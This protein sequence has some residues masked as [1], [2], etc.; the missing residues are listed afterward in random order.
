MFDDKA[1]MSETAYFR[2]PSSVRMEVTDL[3]FGFLIFWVRVQ[4]FICAGAISIGGSPR[5]CRH[6]GLRQNAA[7]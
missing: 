7:V 5:T 6:G 4:P 1:C 2:N 3:L